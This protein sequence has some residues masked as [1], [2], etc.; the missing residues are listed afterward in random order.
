MTMKILKVFLATVTLAL[1]VAAVEEVTDI[2]AHFQPGGEIRTVVRV[3]LDVTGDGEAEIFLTD[4]TLWEKAGRHWR[5]YSPVGSSFHFLGT[6][7]FHETWFEFDPDRQVLTAWQPIQVN[8]FDLVEY[9]VGPDGITELS[10]REMSQTVNGEVVEEAARLEQSIQGYRESGTFH[11]A[12]AAVEDVE[13]GLAGQEIV[14][15][16]LVTRKPVVGLRRIIAARGVAYSKAPTPR[17]LFEHFMGERPFRHSGSVYLFELDVT[18][19]GVRE[20]FLNKELRHSALGWLVYSPAADGYRLLGELALDPARIR[21]SAADAQLVVLRSE[22][23]VVAY[24]RVDA[25]GIRQVREID[26]SMN[27]S[28]LGRPEQERMD[29]W[30]REID[31][32]ILTLPVEELEADPV[33][34]V[35]RELMSNGERAT[36]VDFSRAVVRED[37]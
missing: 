18:G 9:S 13:S 7:R 8:R 16:D 11:A 6:I 15:K 32:E 35:W 19:D 28:R 20:I 25:S 31:F 26:W 2:W 3:D 24:Y 27:W 14:W 29:A 5:V 23:D 37:P 10:R 30:R 36:A 22:P 12:Y 4:A 34:A 21:Y 1:P 33:N 17:N